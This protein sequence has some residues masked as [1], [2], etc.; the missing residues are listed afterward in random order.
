M[1]SQI[2]S[3]RLPSVL[4]IGLFL[5]SVNLDAQ[6]VLFPSHSSDIGENNAWVVR[7]F[8]E[9]PFILDLHVERFSGGSWTSCRP[10]ADCST[11]AGR[12]TFGTPLYAPADGVIK[13]C[14]RNFDDNPKPGE[15]LKR[16][17]G[18][19]GTTKRIFTAG[20]HVNIET[21]DGNVILI[22]HMQ[23]GSVP[24]GLCPFNEE[25]ADV[26]KFGQDYPAAAIIPVG[27]RPQV[28][29][30]QYIGMA[31][32]SGN[33]TGPHVH[34]HMKPVATDTTEGNSFAMPY[35]HGWAQ[36]YNQ[37]AG[38]DADDW[39]K[40]NARAITDASG[41]TLIHPSPF[42]RR[43]S[44]GA[45]A[46]TT[47]EP[48]FLSGNR[49]VTA[50]ETG[51]HDLMLISWDLAGPGDLLRKHDVLEGP[52]TKIKVVAHDST[53]V[54]AAMRDAQGR[55]KLI[56]YQIGV[57]GSFLRLDD[58][59]G[60]EVKDLDIAVT[61]GPDRKIVV[62]MRRNADDKLKL[63]V[64]DLDY[65]T[66]SARLKLLAT[67]QEQGTVSALA[68]A[69]AINFNGA[70]VA[71]RTATGTLKVIPYALSNGGATITRGTD[72]EAGDVSTV[73]DITAIPKGFVTAMKDSNGTLRLISLETSTAGNIAGNI[74]AFDSGNAVSEVRV[75]R[76]PHSAG[77]N[78]VTTVRAADGTLHLVGWAMSDRG[79]NIRRSGS[80]EAGEASKIGAAASYYSVV[81]QQPRDMLLTAMRSSSGDLRLINWEVNLEQQ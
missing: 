76:T 49:A 42:L 35:L 1:T 47:V 19:D 62:A 34:M 21:P 72:Y 7:E 70:G 52:A 32:N 29:R 75:T 38:P 59:V 45:G 26:S 43:A 37:N 30:G 4:A 14:W 16:V 2:Q 65:A 51:D 78:V 3:R 5:L 27:Q 53:N 22:A 63:Q 80:S 44:D 12:L 71:I 17:T 61:Q 67:R 9:G 74:E 13:T 60:D 55:L 25:E 50:L 10:G 28:R 23:K 39:Y 18:E 11:N 36:P 40:L 33:S 6:N 79:A 31:G 15:K 77:G 41:N 57:T 54:V 20:N 48:V 46:T 66:G 81:G 56:L 64:Y 69:G 58:A 8:S 24:P 68:V 73:F